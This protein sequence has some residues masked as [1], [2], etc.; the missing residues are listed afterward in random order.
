MLFLFRI[1]MVQQQFKQQLLDET[2]HKLI[3]FLIKIVSIQERFVKLFYLGYLYLIYANCYRTRFPYLIIFYTCI[4]QRKVLLATVNSS[5]QDPLIQF[6]FSQQQ[7]CI[8]E[9]MIGATN[10][11]V[12]YHQRQIYI[13]HIQ[14]LLE[15][16]YMKMENSNSE[17]LNN[18]YCRNV[19]FSTEHHCQ[20]L[21][22]DQGMMPPCCI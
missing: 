20:Y 12:S 2:C 10:S 8:I 14:V 18:L 5:N 16:C 9:M 22:E 1:A 4:R 6:L 7:I 13:L 3:R 17:Q 19:S 11:S 21:G 15:S